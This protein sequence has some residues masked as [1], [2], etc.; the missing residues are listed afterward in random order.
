MTYINN[1][2]IHLIY[3]IFKFR[4]GIMEKKRPDLKR[5]TIEEKKSLKIDEP[6]DIIEC[7]AEK[8]SRGIMLVQFFLPG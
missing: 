6:E 1:N 7:D 3:S 2:L 5:E 8:K 4:V